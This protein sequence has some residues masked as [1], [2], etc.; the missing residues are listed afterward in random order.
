[1]GRLTV[2]TGVLASQMCSFPLGKHECQCLRGSLEGVALPR[3]DLSIIL[4]SDR[5]RHLHW[6]CGLKNTL[7]LSDPHRSP[8]PQ[9]SRK[10]NN[11]HNITNL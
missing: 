7:P 6:L 8:F 2:E 10:L 11:V 1:M 3:R 4:E 9:M 5:P